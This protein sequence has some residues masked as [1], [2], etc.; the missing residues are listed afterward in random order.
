MPARCQVVGISSF[1]RNLIEQA[2]D[3]PVDYGPDSRAGALMLLIDHELRLQPVLPLSLH[4]PAEGPLA[5]KCRHFLAHPDIKQTIDDWSRELGIARRTFTRLFRHEVGESFVSWRQQAC[6]LVAVPRLIS[7]EPVTTVAMDLG[8]DNP[9]AFTSM[10]KRR[11]GSPPR[12][13]AARENSRA[14]RDGLPTT[15]SPSSPG[16]N[17]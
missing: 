12:T 17:G 15:P 1:M 6:L 13:Y 4:Y 16:S 10:F 2:L 8:Y 11:L 14:F 5:R 9:A 3:L 7:G